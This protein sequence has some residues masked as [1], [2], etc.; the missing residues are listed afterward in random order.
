[1]SPHLTRY[2]FT[3]LQTSICQSSGLPLCLVL[4]L[5]NDCIREQRA[6]DNK[7]RLGR[8]ISI[9]DVTDLWKASTANAVGPDGG[10]FEPFGLFIYPG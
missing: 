1:M 4:A 7:G 6:E 10:A 3:Q 8:Q 9:T 2:Q 5:Y